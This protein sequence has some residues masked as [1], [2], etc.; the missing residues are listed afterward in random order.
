LT[1]CPSVFDRH[2][3]LLDVTCVCQASAKSGEILA[4]RFGRCE[5]KKSN[6]WRR[7]LLA[8]R[9]QTAKRLPNQ[10]QVL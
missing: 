5:M 1:L 7:R 3:L 2:V 8:R 6:Y 10:Q 4:C 9:P